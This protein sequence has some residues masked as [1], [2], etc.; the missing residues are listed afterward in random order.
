[1]GEKM[2]TVLLTG[3]GG[4]VG[5]N[6]K[7][8]FENLGWRVIAPRS[9][10]YDFTDKKTVLSLAQSARADA[11]V[12][13]GFYGIEDIHITQSDAIEKNL[14]IFNNFIAASEGKTVITFGSGAEFD[15]SR[16]IVKAKE[17]DLGKVIP[18]NVY[19]KA[20]YLI[21]QEIKKY[22]N[23]YNLR[24]FGVYGPHERE[25][26]FITY[27]IMQN[28]KKEPININQNVV[29][30]YLYAEDLCKAVGEFIKNPPSERF[31][32]MTPPK[33]TDLINICNI[34]NKISSFKS[35][36]NIIKPGLNN[37]YTGDNAVLQKMLPGFAFTSYEDGI[38]KFYNY[39]KN[40]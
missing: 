29:F 5:K 22:Q 38:K 37:E 40:N 7:P 12:L 16:P 9:A 30:D 27:A 19:G 28:L 10:E 20:K 3:S 31:I 17:S 15:K 1:M 25:Q 18:Q 33:S 4:F 8:H 13:A 24:L 11:Y 34:I 39:L 32:N 36:V 14:A 21:S 35:P 26:R 23:A 6:L 2:K